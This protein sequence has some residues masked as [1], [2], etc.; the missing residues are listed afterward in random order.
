M[1]YKDPI[2]SMLNDFDH[3]LNQKALKLPLFVIEGNNSYKINVDMPG[4]SK[5]N[6][7]LKVDNN[8]L[9]IST[10]T[11]A[12]QLL[13]NEKAIISEKFYGQM[14]RELELPKNIDSE[15][16]IAKYENGVLY[17]V[18]TKIDVTLNKNITIQ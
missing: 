8:L 16:I 12:P 1:F 10:L 4:V 5:E 7:N 6:I 18:L 3:L 2:I 17:I 15:N 9:K 11:K 14:F 13:E